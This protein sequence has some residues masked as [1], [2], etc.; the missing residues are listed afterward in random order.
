MSWT[1]QYRSKLV[2]AREAVSCVESGMRVYIH[3]GCAEPE[4]LVEALIGRAPFVTDVEVMH[5][6][7]MG[8]SPYCVPEMAAHFRHNALFVGGNVREAVNDGR[9]DYTPIFLGEVEAL[10]E[11]GE[12]PIDVAFIQV[13]LPDSHGYCSFGVGVD[14]TLTAAKCAHYVVAQVNAQMPRTYGDS[15]IHVSKIDAIVELSRPLCELKV[16]PSSELF[17][18]IGT[19][20]ASLIE[21]GAVLQC[22]IGGIPDAVLPN[23][24]D[25]KDLGVHTELLSDNIIP[26]IEADV[27][28]GQR[29]NVKPRKV[30]VGFVLGTKKLFDFIDENPIFE[31]HP[32]AYTNDPFRIA[33][34]DRMVAINSAI[35]V[36]LTGQV[37][38]ESIGSQ[39]YS[40]F[41]GQ[42]DFVRGAARSKYGKP[43]IAL[44]ATAKHDTVSRIVPRLANGAGVLTT[45]ADVHYV[46]TEYGVAYLH[47][48]TVRQRA[49]SLIQIAHPKF[50]DELYDYCE[51]QRW[52]Q[53]NA[54]AAEVR[55]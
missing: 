18:T 35:E 33:Q 2:T 41:G 44:P 50:H 5:L 16:Q 15:F 1:D 48:R 19:R 40:G 27:V 46:V 54:Y 49:E 24:M 3:P 22:G 55:G 6:L 36:D 52:F 37:C 12:M 28:N 13:S 34:N 21:D 42:L 10:F 39:F 23:L 51:R 7:T 32:S 4:A 38:A 53:R 45:R 17:R 30:I 14:C 11:S 31:F 26:L 8:A 20:V 25:R 29:K 47:G 43:I 9:A